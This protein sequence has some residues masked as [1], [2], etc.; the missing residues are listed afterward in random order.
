M[1]FLL[2][3]LFA[4]VV[5][6]FVSWL[7]GRAPVIAGLIAALP[8]STMLI[9]PLSQIQY[10]DVENTVVLARS[11]LLATPITLLFFVPFVFADRLAWSFWQLYGAGFALLVVGFGLFR[12]AATLFLSEAD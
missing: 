12:L 8:L 9:L 1:T 2:N 11:I 3:T 4:A 7:S 5:I 6:A 10:G